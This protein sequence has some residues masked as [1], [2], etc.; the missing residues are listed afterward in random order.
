MPDLSA[1]IVRSVIE[2]LPP[3]YFNDDTNPPPRQVT[4]TR[5]KLHQ[6]F[7]AAGELQLHDVSSDSNLAALQVHAPA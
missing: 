3:R 4:A 5:S 2:L 1:G 6:W 7:L